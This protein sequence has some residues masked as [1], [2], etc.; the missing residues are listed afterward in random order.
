MFGAE[1]G[2]TEDIKRLLIDNDPYVLVFTVV[3]SILHTIMDTLAFK[4]GSNP[5]IVCYSSRSNPPRRTILEGEK[6]HG[7]HVDTVNLCEHN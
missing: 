6:V 7:R 5:V 3:V 1:E 2:E 4:N